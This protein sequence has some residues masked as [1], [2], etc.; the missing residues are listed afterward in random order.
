MFPPTDSLIQA[1]AFPDSFELMWALTATKKRGSGSANDFHALSLIK[2]YTWLKIGKKPLVTYI[3]QGASSNCLKVT[4]QPLVKPLC[5]AKNRH[6]LILLPTFST[7]QIISQS[8]TLAWQLSYNKTNNT[9]FWSLLFYSF[10][11]IVWT[12]CRKLLR[13]TNLV[14]SLWEG[15]SWLR[16]HFGSWQRRSSCCFDS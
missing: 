6:N 4:V 12:M 15:V 5:F 11:V 13:Y 10:L 16:V 1:A 7:V 3:Q 14:T 2:K 8:N 9:L